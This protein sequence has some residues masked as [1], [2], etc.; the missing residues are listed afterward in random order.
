MVLAHPSLTETAREEIACDYFVDALDDP[1]FALKVRERAPATLDEALRVAFQLEAWTK[2]A[3]CRNERSIQGMKVRKADAEQDMQ[4]TNVEKRLKRLETRLSRGLIEAHPSP[5]IP[6]KHQ[7]EQHAT[8]TEKPH[9]PSYT[10]IAQQIEE[11]L[12]RQLKEKLHAELNAEHQ[13]KPPPAQS[14]APLNQVSDNRPSGQHWAQGNGNYGLRIYQPNAGY[15]QT[16]NTCWCCGLPGHLKHNCTQASSTAN[17][18]AVE[19]TPMQ[20]NATN[21]AARGSKMRDKANVYLSM[22]INGRSYLCL[23]DS[24]CEYTMIP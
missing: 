13:L 15:G 23:L 7:G 20:N 10:Q 22:D 11:K 8:R 9:E 16:F 1:D 2:E 24:G 3:K 5:K 6:Q 12:R 4:V 21:S 18:D 14:L 19:E 17:R